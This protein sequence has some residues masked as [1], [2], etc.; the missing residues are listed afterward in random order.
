MLNAIKYNTITNLNS[1]RL[2]NKMILNINAIT[3][4]VRLIYLFEI[5]IEFSFIQ[6]YYGCSSI[7]LSNEERGREI[8]FCLHRRISK[9]NL[10]SNRN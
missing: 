2:T 7:S 1:L 6:G 9:K 8:R 3:N 10:K 4:L 5:F